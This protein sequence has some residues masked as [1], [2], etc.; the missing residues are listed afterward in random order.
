[1]KMNDKDR[2]EMMSLNE[3]LTLL[4]QKLMEGEGEMPDMEDMESVTVKGDS[5]EAVKEGLDMA[6][7]V[8]GEMPDDKME[9]DYAATSE[10]VGADGADI[11][12][13]EE[14]DEELRKKLDALMRA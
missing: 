4:S 1:M 12:E 9:E 6:E 7:E 3:L 10:D 8:V 13:D 11:E 2:A 5:P 14:D